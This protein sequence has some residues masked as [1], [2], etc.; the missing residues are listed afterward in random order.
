MD[1]SNSKSFTDLWPSACWLR[2]ATAVSKPSEHYC[3]TDM[4]QKAVPANVN[5]FTFGSV[6]VVAIIIISNTVQK[7]MRL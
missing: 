3:T 6:S 5:L 2:A 7:S 4:A 1:N